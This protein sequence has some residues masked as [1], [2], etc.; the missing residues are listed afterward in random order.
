MDARRELSFFL[1]LA[2]VIPIPLTVVMFFLTGPLVRFI[3]GG[4]AFTMEDA[5]TVTRVIEY[6]II[7]LPFFCTNMLFVKYANAR[8]KNSLIMISSLLGLVLNVILNFVFIGRMGVAGIALATSLSM[9]CSTMLFIVV[10]HRYNDVSWVDV[11]FT[12]LTW[13][14]FLTILLCYH[15]R[16]MSGVIIAS[17]SLLLTVVYHMVEFFERKRSVQMTGLAE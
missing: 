12:V 15:F 11:V 4:G 6:G 9:M 8:R 5:G 13:L 2:T 14:L 3:F 1:F 10:G 16:S 17:T 7:Q